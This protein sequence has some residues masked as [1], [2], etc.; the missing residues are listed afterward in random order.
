M[1][2]GID[3][4]LAHRRLRRL[5]LFALDPSDNPVVVVSPPAGSLG[6]RR[7]AADGVT[8]GGPVPTGFASSA[9]TGMF[10]MTLAFDAAGHPVIVDADVVQAQPQQLIRLTVCQ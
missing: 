10:M 6:V 5:A 8:W 7:C 9:P 2:R 4:P 1:I 3:A